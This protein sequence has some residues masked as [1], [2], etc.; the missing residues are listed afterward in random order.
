MFNK[1]DI[2]TAK[3]LGLL[4]EDKG[5]QEQFILDPRGVVFYGSASKDRVNSL[6][7]YVKLPKMND[8]TKTLFA[9]WQHIDSLTPGEFYAHQVFHY[10]GNL[11]GF[12]Y[13]PN[14][15][16][17]K[18]VEKPSEAVTALVLTSASRVEILEAVYKI[19]NSGI[20]LAE[21]TAR[22]FFFILKELKAVFLDVL[23]ISRNKE[24]N[25]IVYNEL[26]IV[27][28]E[29]EEFIRY[30]INKVTGSTLV[31][32]N[33]TTLAMLREN[34]SLA[35]D[36]LESYKDSY[37]LAELAKVYNRYKPILLAIKYGASKPTI[38]KISKL[39]KKLH[40]P[41]KTPSFMKVTSE[42]VEPGQLEGAS[43]AQLVRAYNS[44]LNFASENKVYKVRN[45]KVFIQTA[46]KEGKTKALVLASNQLAIAKV[47]QG[48]FAKLQGLKVYIPDGVRY[49]V[50]TSEK[51]F[52]GAIPEGTILSTEGDNCVVGVYWKGQGVDL[53][54]HTRGLNG[55]HVGWNSHYGQ[56]GIVFSGDITSA[57]NG[58]TEVV[59]I[60][61]GS[62]AEN[63]ALALSL[64]PYAFCGES[65]A[66]H[67]LVGKSNAK[68]LSCIDP[69]SIKIAA[70]MEIERGD[71]LNLGTV[72]ADSEGRVSFVVGSSVIPNQGRVPRTDADIMDTLIL[73]SRDKALNALSLNDFLELCGAELV[74]H[75]ECDLDL[76]LESLNKEKILGL[77]S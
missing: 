42:I 66:F 63:K 60:P 38:N 24:F 55:L 9:S 17:Y 41:L 29:G 65:H 19:L 12:E 20:P 45:G 52:V 53:D 73:G 5:V 71:T 64:S 15:A 48:R 18:G 56:Y 10:L 6:A 30:L 51:N 69:K 4:L 3:H 47:L 13:A 25:S 49:A 59:K 36:L 70:P 23:K 37:G 26:G 61:K 50:P 34:A 54:L 44:I 33:K 8:M 46:R 32:K 7:S 40:K 57:P 68:N 14:S 72:I 58:A 67:L 22:D 28:K 43:T 11:F 74:S 16:V 2:A 1:L 21:E 35:S 76:S 27:P 77:M 62:L 75:E 31:I 39:S